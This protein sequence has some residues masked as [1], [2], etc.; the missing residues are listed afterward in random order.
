MKELRKL[1]NLKR[2]ELYDTEFITE[3]AFK[4]FNSLKSLELQFWNVTNLILNC[5]AENCLQLESLLIHCK[6]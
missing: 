3:E 2:L 5:I 4:D 6:Y 1:R